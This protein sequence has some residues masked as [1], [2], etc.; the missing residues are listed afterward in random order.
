MT[1]GQRAVARRPPRPLT[2]AVALFMLLGN[3]CETGVDIPDVVREPEITGEIAVREFVDGSVVEVETV[4]GEQVRIE[5]NRTARIGGSTDPD[6]GDL[7]LYGTEPDGPWFW[8]GPLLDDPRTG[9]NCAELM[10]PALEDG[11]FIV[12]EI[13]VRLPKAP[14]FDPF[15]VTDGQFTDPT[16]GFC[17]NERGEVTRYRS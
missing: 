1:P 5:L 15:E 17:L 6:E 8:S 4:Q 12:F 13:G 10:A 7:L 3:A 9:G 11:N 2:L 14:D 16:K